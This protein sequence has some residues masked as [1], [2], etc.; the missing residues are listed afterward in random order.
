MI[1]LIDVASFSVSILADSH[2]QYVL[3]M[4]TQTCYI[5]LFIIKLVICQKYVF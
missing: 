2:Y 5:I 3:G 1:N 4:H